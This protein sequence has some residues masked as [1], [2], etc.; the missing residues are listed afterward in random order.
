MHAS[1][2]HHITE[3]PSGPDVK[4]PKT[5]NCHIW[6]YS[7][8][9]RFV[10]QHAHN[11]DFEQ[12]KN[13]RN[14][15][16]N[17]SIMAFTE[18]ELQSAILGEANRAKESNSD[19][20][21]ITH[22]LTFDR[23]THL[24][25]QPLFCG[26][27]TLAIA[28][29][30][31]Q[32]KVVTPILWVRAHQS[33]RFGITITSCPQILIF[34]AN[35]LV[36]SDVLFAKELGS[37]TNKDLDFVSSSLVKPRPMMKLIP[38]R[39]DTITD[40]FNPDNSHRSVRDLETVFKNRKGDHDK[41]VYSWLRAAAMVKDTTLTNNAD[42][43]SQMQ[44][45]PA[46]PRDFTLDHSEDVYA[47]LKTGFNED[48]QEFGTAVANG[49][50]NCLSKEFNPAQPEVIDVDTSPRSNRQ[51]TGPS[52]EA[53]PTNEAN[54]NAV[55][56]RNVLLEE[57]LA[58]QKRIATALARQHQAATTTTGNVS[59]EPRGTG[60]SDG[61]PFGTGQPVGFEG[62]GLP[63]GNPFGSDS[64]STFQQ[65]AATFNNPFGA[66]A[67]TN[68]FGAAPLGTTGHTGHHSAHTGMASNAFAFGASASNG[69]INFGGR[70]QYAPDPTCPSPHQSVGD[71]LQAM[72]N[73][74]P[75]QPLTT[76]DM[77]RFQL[78]K[79]LASETD[80]RHPN[81]TRP[82]KPKKV[83]DNMGTRSYNLCGWAHLQPHELNSLHRCNNGGWLHFNKASDKCDK[84][85]VIDTYFIQPLIKKNGRFRQII[86]TEFRKSIIDWRL[87]PSNFEG[88]K[89]HG[90]LGPLTYVNRSTAEMERVEYHR[91]LNSQVIPTTADMER[92]IPGT[93]QIPDTIDALITNLTLT[94][95]G[96]VQVV[97]DRAPPPVQLQ[98]LLEALFDNYSRLAAKSN[99]RTLISNEIIYQLCRHLERYFGV[100]CT[101]E[102]V[103]ARRFPV[104]NIDFLILG[105]ENNNLSLSHSYGPIFLPKKAPTQPLPRPSPATPN[106]RKRNQDKSPK[107][108]DKPTT[109]NGPGCDAIRK[110]I[111][112]HRAAHDNKFPRLSD[113]RI[114]N[115]F[116]STKEMCEALGLKS[117]NCLNYGLFCYCNGKCKNTH[118]SD[119]SAYKPDKAL[120]MLTKATTM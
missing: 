12:L 3:K 59:F 52:P 60:Q 30:N 58:E 62:S 29:V 20:Q 22:K 47:D 53:D 116:N 96:L 16:L 54:L 4:R 111:A 23:T 117:S 64:S 88:T 11:L 19:I 8:A 110:L 109:R 82:D 107:K 76:E 40:F 57:Q 119:F 104:F 49:I 86:T 45:E 46:Q 39:A 67:T 17:I 106:D 42:S 102:D 98:R 50:L 36:A 43:T 85:S 33:Q 25:I 9:I 78:L 5:I 69:S 91:A 84:E 77:N 37:N 35:D 66:P 10:T 6:H 114:A 51:R 24:P 75:G 113:I 28:V 72:L 93:P 112:D 100:F 48:D 97:G 55:L 15:D 2:A 94:Q 103:A 115:E 13:A 21:I 81:S 108:S 105:I 31:T 80:K 99:F 79:F 73:R 87:A 118:Q 7:G 34:D 74:G 41:F 27:G 70:A 101:A 18:G 26:V 44:L 14:P 32:P 120:A 95:L 56:Q 71:Q 89:P 38:I 63:Y 90:G 68:P 92:S 61:L 1:P 83:K 65:P